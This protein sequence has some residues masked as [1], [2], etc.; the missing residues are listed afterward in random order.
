MQIVALAASLAASLALVYY[1]AKQAG[2][3]RE[4]EARRRSE[5]DTDRRNADQRSQRSLEYLAGHLLSQVEIVDRA[6]VE[7]VLYRGL[8]DTALPRMSRE[9]ADLLSL[10]RETISADLESTHR[11]VTAL[12]DIALYASGAQKE[13]PNELTPDQY[14]ALFASLEA[15][16]SALELLTPN[17]L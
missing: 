11:A 8:R 5:R 6:I 13:R 16:R 10:A 7:N 1:A 2:I 14:A 3:M 9:I 15:A 12:T 17:R 4:S